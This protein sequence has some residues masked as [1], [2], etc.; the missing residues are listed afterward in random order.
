M[1]RRIGLFILPLILGILLGAVC[2][3]QHHKKLWQN[4]IES[5]K[6]SFFDSQYGNNLKFDRLP[7]Q[8][9]EKAEQTLQLPDLE[10]ATQIESLPFYQR[11]SLEE[12]SKL[13]ERLHRFRQKQVELTNQKIKE[14]K[15]ELN[16]EQKKEFQKSLL[17][18]RKTNRLSVQSQMKELMQTLEQK[19]NEELRKDFTK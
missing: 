12:R 18:K 19:S 2:V 8:V 5:K 1:V 4:K 6:D 15:L 17:E 10:L 11:L 7:P 16:E 14:L 13:M 3:H 9:L